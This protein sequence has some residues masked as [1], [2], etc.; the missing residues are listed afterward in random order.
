MNYIRYIFT[1][2]W[3]MQLW[4][5][6]QGGVNIVGQTD[7]TAPVFPD[8]DGVTVPYNIAPLNL[9]LTEPGEYHLN[10]AGTDGEI[11]IRSKDLFPIPTRR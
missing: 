4:A 1:L 5:C 2:I 7:G 9:S 8:Y 10:I 11:N 6:S 3:M